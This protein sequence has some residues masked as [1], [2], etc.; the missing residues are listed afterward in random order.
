[1]IERKT[2]FVFGA[3]AS[4]DF[5]FP[6][7]HE[8]RTRIAAISART[9]A[10]FENLVRPLI[11]VLANRKGGARDQFLAAAA[12]LSD[13][14]PSQ[15]SIDD[16]LNQR[17]ENQD[18]VNLGKA[19]IAREILACESNS[20]LAQVVSRGTKFHRIKAATEWPG[21]LANML[22]RGY[23]QQEAH[24][25]FDNTVF[26]TYNYDRSLEVFLMHA[27][28]EAFSMEPIEFL[29]I[30]RTAPICHVYGSVGGI[31]DNDP[32]NNIPFGAP[33]TNFN[34]S[35]A[36]ESLR[37]YTQEEADGRVDDFIIRHIRDAERLIFLGCAYHNLNIQIFDAA[38]GLN[39]EKIY[40][41]SHGLSPS[42]VSVAKRRLDGIISPSNDH[43]QPIVQLVDA[44][45][46]KFLT[47][48]E[49]ALAE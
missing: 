2:V 48:Y 3:G 40:G 46:T 24:K 38:H 49:V 4:W 30:L 7:G 37:T 22:H 8:L 14:L 26:L 39:V 6:L 47:D 44:L 41:T 9:H 35:R 5:G 16:F 20:P 10:E 17:S 19:L 27:L 13:A 45:C 42:A 15:K 28:S 21:I 34:Y 33:L 29:K 23:R 32:A 31:L 1:M 11:E 18:I 36:V 12:D 43:D 25:V